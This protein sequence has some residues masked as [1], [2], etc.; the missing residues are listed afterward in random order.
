MGKYTRETLKGEAFDFDAAMEQS[1]EAERE[2]Y[3]QI[4]AHA[5]LQHTAANGQTAQAEA[6]ERK[7]TVT[8]EQ[9]AKQAAIR[10]LLIRCAVVVGIFLA[11]WL[12]QVWGLIAMELALAAGTCA[13]VWICIW[14]GAWIQFAWC[15]GGLLK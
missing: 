1:P 10:S 14:F 4:N 6:V 11:L 5:D 2:I 9:L 15:K 12:F 8:K 13:L 7:R 3:E